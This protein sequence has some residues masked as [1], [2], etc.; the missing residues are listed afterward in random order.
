MRVPFQEIQL[1]VWAAKLVASGES[2][3]P[4]ADKSDSLICF[5]QIKSALVWKLER[6]QYEQY[7]KPCCV[8]RII[9]HSLKSYY[10]TR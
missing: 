8:I 10:R 9:P 6:V 7:V 2:V 1:S 4:Y 3:E 5:R